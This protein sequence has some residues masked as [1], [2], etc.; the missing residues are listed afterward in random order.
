MSTFLQLCQRLSSEVGGAGTSP[1]AVTS[2]TGMALRYVN[3]IASAWLDIQRMHDDWKFMRGSFT[4]NT[5][6]DDG[7]Y[8]YTDCTD[9]ATSS[10]I[11][12]FRWWH[13]DTFK[14]YLQSAGVGSEIPLDY[15]DYDCWYR[16]YN[17]GTQTSSSPWCF[18]IDHSNG[19][20][21]GPKPSAVYVVSGEFQKAAT[22][23]AADGDTP[24][25]P[26]EFHDAIVYLAMKKYARYAGA[27]EI[28]DDVKGEYRRIISEMERTQL[29]ELLM[30][31]PLT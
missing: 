9:T 21:L 22:T 26:S 18:T 20:R 10:A 24:S 8:V 2:Q 25:A 7:A 19:F 13:R 5:V 12:S 11:A 27:P 3:W 28:Y 29:P 6:A 31:G 4:V 23:L 14:S 17:T 1:S 30:A 15:I 16:Q